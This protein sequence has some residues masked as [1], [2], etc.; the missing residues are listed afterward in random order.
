MAFDLLIHRLG[1]VVLYR[2]FKLV[3]ASVCLL[4]ASLANGLYQK[5]IARWSEKLHDL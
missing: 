5:P 3:L 2:G 4:G 1:N